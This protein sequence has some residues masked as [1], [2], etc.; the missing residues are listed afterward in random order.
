MN[1]PWIGTP[2]AYVESASPPGY[3]ALAPASEQTA[4]AVV[5]PGDRAGEPEIDLSILGDL[6]ITAADVGTFYDAGPDHWW[7]AAPGGGLLISD[8]PWGEH[9]PV[10]GAVYLMPWDAAW[11]SQWAFD[12]EA[13]AAALN[14]VLSLNLSEDG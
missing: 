9:I 11:F 4:P 10:E 1:D 2:T 3:Q 12:W 13:A 8:L 5:E 6:T 7:W 14:V